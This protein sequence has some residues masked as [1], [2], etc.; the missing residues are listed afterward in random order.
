MGE[1]A[2]PHTVAAYYLAADR[3]QEALDA[4]RGADPEDVRACALRA[5]A[6]LQLQRGAE[7][8]RY[9]RTALELRPEEP[10][11][12][13]L[14]AQTQ[15]TYDAF[16]AE[17]TLRKALELEPEN[18][19]LFAMYVLILMEQGRYEWAERMLDRGMKIAP[20]EM[21]ATRAIFLLRASSS[22]EA[23][24]AAQEMLREAPDDATAHYLQGL[25]LLGSGRVSRG[26]RHLREA[27]ALRPSDPLFASAARTFGAWYL[28][29]VY[30]TAGP[31]HALLWMFFVLGGLAM[32]FIAEDIGVF[33]QTAGV[34][35]AFAVYKWIAYAAMSR[36][37]QRRVS[38]ASREL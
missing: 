35:M 1:D 18:A 6:L 2:D 13:M 16:A 15:A 36:T 38:R 3:P 5:Q 23:L 10:V 27:A 25:A 7:A 28:W 22:R 30:L 34:F 11:L 14:L 21:Q 8:E 24:N 4:L 20:E 26:L 37:L 32:A 17:D 9:L 12:L 31:V 19:S 29:P 33:W